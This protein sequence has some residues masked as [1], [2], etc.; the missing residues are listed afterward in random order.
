CCATANAISFLPFDANSMSMGGAGSVTG[1]GGD[2]PYLNPAAIADSQNRHVLDA[3][4]GARVIDREHF[5]ET[6]EEIEETFER[7]QLEKKFRNARRA[8]RSGNLDSNALRSL[9][10]TAT[11]VLD[12]INKLPDRYIRI[13]ASGGAHVLS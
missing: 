5:I 9:A 8:F 7:L 6:F 13:A 2:R 4:L 3:Y 11:Q 10:T 1:V 12:E